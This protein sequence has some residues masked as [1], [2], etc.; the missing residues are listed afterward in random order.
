METSE[1]LSPALVSIVP[2]NSISKI[3]FIF[4]T[5]KS[6]TKVDEDMTNLAK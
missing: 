3:R 6:R 2:N 5:P 4:N 1:L